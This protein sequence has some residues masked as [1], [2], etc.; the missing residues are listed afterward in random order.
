MIADGG[1][2]LFAGRDAS[3]LGEESMSNYHDD[4]VE[5]EDD[6]DMDDPADDMVE[7]NQERGLRDSDSEDEEYGRS[8]CMS[9]SYFV[10]FRHYS[11]N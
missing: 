1:C 5:M 10:F 3:L 8:V 11:W 7:G 2:V 4:H 6:Y 9:A